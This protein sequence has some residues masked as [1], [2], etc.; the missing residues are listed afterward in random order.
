[1]QIVNVTDMTTEYNMVCCP[2]KM[3]QHTL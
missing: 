3:L 2:K 1:M